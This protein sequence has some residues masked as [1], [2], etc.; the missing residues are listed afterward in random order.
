MRSEK[1]YI[2]YGERIVISSSRE[3]MV[4][5]SRGIEIQA[6]YYARCKHVHL[7]HKYHLFPNFDELVF[8]LHP[9]LN[10]EAF[11]EYNE[12]GST[13]PNK[14]ILH[15]RMLLEE[16]LNAA[17]IEENRGKQVKLGSVVQIFHVNSRTYLSF[18]PQ[19]VSD[20]EMGVIGCSRENSES[21]QFVINS[22]FDFLKE[23]SLISYEDKFV[24]V[25]SYSKTL[26]YPL[27]SEDRD[28]VRMQIEVK[29]ERSFMQLFNSTKPKDL[30]MPG[31]LE[32]Q[33]LYETYQ[34]G[35]VHQ[36]SIGSQ[37]FNQFEAAIQCTS[38]RSTAR[39]RSP[40]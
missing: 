38:R 21:V 12:C 20:S 10:Y 11:L 24:F 34:A 3:S 22:P 32:T 1:R 5:G 18:S 9:C 39:E 13:D 8:E 15:K 31:I 33:K 26:A 30:K 29:V 35:Y 40:C 17:K 36:K 6:G 2:R 28:K 16:N 4:L 7:A 25:D 27:S 23:G 37:F 19:K 14:E